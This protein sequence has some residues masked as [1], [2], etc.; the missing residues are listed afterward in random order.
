MRFPSCKCKWILLAAALCNAVLE[1]DEAEGAVL[2]VSTECCDV[3][4]LKRQVSLNMKDA[5]LNY[6][7]PCIFFKLMQRCLTLKKDV[8]NFGN[9]QLCE[10]S[11]LRI[12]NFENTQLW[13]YS[14][15]LRHFNF[16]MKMI[17]MLKLFQI[18]EIWN[19]QNLNIKLRFWH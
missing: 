1:D 13:E 9:N 16:L 10:Y 5:K 12:F 4:H 6:S 7:M 19:Y 8:L 14:H 3:S 2:L 18:W 11:T 17:L 15:I